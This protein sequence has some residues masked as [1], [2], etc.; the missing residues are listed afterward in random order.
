MSSEPVLLYRA[1]LRFG[2]GLNF[3]DKSYFYRRYSLDI[4]SSSS[5]LIE[6]FQDKVRV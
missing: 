5:A 6:L 1:L 2:R 3:T 4:Y